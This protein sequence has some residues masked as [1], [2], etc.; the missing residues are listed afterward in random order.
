MKNL[1]VLFLAISGFIG[2]GRA[3]IEPEFQTYYN[4]FLDHLE[5]HEIELIHPLQLCSI[6]FD[7]EYKEKFMPKEEGKFCSETVQ[8]SYFLPAWSGGIAVGLSCHSESVVV[9][10]K[11]RY[12]EL[13]E[14][15]KRNLIYHELAHCITGEPHSDELESIMRGDGSIL[16]NCEEIDYDYTFEKI[17]DR[18][19]N[20]L[21]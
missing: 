10:W 4:E 14:C 6:Y 19:D 21:N 11:K 9:I 2:C 15:G 18:L 3:Y 16:H 8:K 17:K 7:T 13:S 12:E 5:K 20:N 1:V